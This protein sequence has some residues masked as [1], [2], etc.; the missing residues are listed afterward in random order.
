[1]PSPT[2]IEGTFDFNFI[3]DG[4]LHVPKRYRYINIKSAKKLF[5]TTRIIIN[6]EICVSRHSTDP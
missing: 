3:G 2:D 5:H 6:L 4:F 1:M